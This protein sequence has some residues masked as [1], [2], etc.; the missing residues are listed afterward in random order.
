MS[1][2]EVPTPVVVSQKGALV[3]D[4]NVAPAREPDFSV[5]SEKVDAQ[6]APARERESKTVDAHEVVVKLD[7][8]ITDPSS[9]LAV[10]VPDAGR[11]SLDLPIH[12][13]AGERA[14][15]VFAREASEITED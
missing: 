1:E 14:E 12:A 10:Q 6:V 8:V 2:V 3:G 15:D 5:N 13:L 7:E 9:P 4:D 11:G